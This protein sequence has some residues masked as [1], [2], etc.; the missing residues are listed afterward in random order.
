MSI[1]IKPVEKTD[2]HA[3]L[4]VGYKERVIGFAKAALDHLPAYLKKWNPDIRIIVLA[5]NVKK[6]F[7]KKLNSC[8]MGERKWKKV[9]LSS[10][11]EGFKPNISVF[12]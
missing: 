9:G 7:T 8:M 6:L 2:H 11:K 12:L 4:H 3:I 1:E 10:W 5:V